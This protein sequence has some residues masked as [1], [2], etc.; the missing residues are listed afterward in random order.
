[1]KVIFLIDGEMFASLMLFVFKIYDQTIGVQKAM[2]EKRFDDA[3]K[4]RGR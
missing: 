1:M 2:D 3:V 4:L